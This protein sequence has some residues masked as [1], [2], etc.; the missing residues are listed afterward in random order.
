[1]EPTLHHGQYLMVNKLALRLG[2]PRRGDIVVFRSPQDAK[3]AL[4]K[5][6]I[7]LPGEEVSIR[8]GLVHINGQPLAEPYIAPDRS[9][10]NWGPIML[11]KGQYV[12]L[13][14]N[15]NNSNDSRGFGPVSDSQFIGKAWFSLWP[16]SYGMVLPHGSSQATGALLAAP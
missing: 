15:R 8:D 13:G 6:V 7:G 1:M 14:D 2:A 10:G 16:P 9:S 12:M 5:R 3:R 4:I 11:G